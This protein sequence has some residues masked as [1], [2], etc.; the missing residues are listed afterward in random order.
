MARTLNEEKHTERRNEI[1]DTA[2][3]LVYTK[4]YEQMTIQDILDDLHISKGAFYHYFD[5]KA[6][7]LEAMVERMIAEQVIPLLSPII[8]DPNLTAIE[9]FHH[10]Y[11]AAS[12]WK[13][14][15]KTFMLEL[16]QVW[17]GDEN[18]IV[19][20]K[21]MASSIRS[22]APLL[23]K[24]IYQ[25]IGEGVFSSPYPDQMSNVIIYIMEGLSEKLSELLISA[26]KRQLDGDV[27]K[28]INTY[29]GAMNDAVERVLGAPK[30]SLKLI[31]P[32]LMK[33]WFE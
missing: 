20:Q 23:T 21:L 4:G 27:D 2:M 30:D 5:S 31:D 9:K 29:I 12:R 7:V 13:I 26:M 32:Q 15:Q 6:E 17:M 28:E 19:R 3:K 1:L 16:L 18:A 25:G 14:S 10:F 11:E 33:V 8:D 22:V 24:I